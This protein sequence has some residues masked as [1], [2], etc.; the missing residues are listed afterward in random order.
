MSEIKIPGKIYQVGGSVR[1]GIMGKPVSDIDYVVVG[2]TQEQMLSAGFKQA[3]KDFPVF[4]HPETKDEY[5]LAR[6]ERKTGH[7][8]HGFT[9]IFDATITLEEDLKRRDLT[10]NA[11]AKDSE[12]RII[13]PYNGRQDIEKKE[14]KHVSES[15][16]EDPLRILRVARFAAR[17]NFSI[18]AETMKLMQQMYKSGETNHLTIERIWKETNRALMHENF[19]RYF[20][21]LNEIGILNQIFPYPFDTKNIHTFKKY[22]ADFSEN[23]HSLES[24]LS[25]LCLPENIEEAVDTEKV[26]HFLTENKIPNKTIQYIT[27]CCN[28]WNIFHNKEESIRNKHNKIW[29]QALSQQKVFVNHKVNENLIS[30]FEDVFNHTK[31]LTGG[32]F[33]PEKKTI[34]SW[35]EGL[36]INQGEIAKN[37]KG[38]PTENI[39]NAI[40]I[41]RQESW[42]SYKIEEIKKNKPKF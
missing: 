3:G 28:F 1:D 8:Y 21:T 42:A 34:L 12:G 26:I 13:D 25:R 29:Y 20:E 10:M 2:A 16:S 5:A 40:E 19:S 35:I 41:A 6:T 23:S 27:M 37:M 17:F 39:K 38:Q 18:N 24:R 9:T 32:D 4:L 15:F 36:N 14:L 33:L 22:E 31:L 30:A 11:M 7:G